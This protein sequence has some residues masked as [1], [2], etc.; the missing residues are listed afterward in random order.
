MTAAD[1]VQI[2]VHSLDCFVV[3]VGEQIDGGKQNYS[4][5][6]EEARQL[7]VGDYVLRVHE[8]ECR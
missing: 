6:K 5:T 2:V 7:V 1:E 4:Q 3:D 8:R